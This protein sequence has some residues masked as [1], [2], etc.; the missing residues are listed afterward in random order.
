MRA[1]SSPDGPPNPIDKLARIFFMRSSR[2]VRLAG[3]SATKVFIHINNTN[4]VLRPD[5]EERAKAEAAGWIVGQDGLEV[6]P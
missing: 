1:I 5:S 2:L 3:L 6:T 4:P